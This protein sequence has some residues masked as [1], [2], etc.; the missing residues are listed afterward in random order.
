MRVVYWSWVLRFGGVTL[1]C[2]SGCSV[3]YDLSPDQCERSSECDSFGQGY[4]CEAGICKAPPGGGSSGKNGGGTA[5]EGFGGG[6]AGGT[7]EPECL[8]NAE[9]EAIHGLDD[10]HRCEDG[11]CEPVPAECATHSDCFEL[12]GDVEPV[13]CVEGRCKFLKTDECPVVV[14]TAKAELQES[15]LDY[16]AILLGAYAFV[17]PTSLVGIQTRNY[18]LVLSDFF[19]EVNGIGSPR[20]RA[21]LIVCDYQVERQANL[22][23]S[24]GHLIDELKVPAILGG[25][26]AADLQY[27]FDQKGQSADVFFLAPNYAD[28]TLVNYQD[29]GLIWHM[30]SGAEVLGKSYA[31]LLDLSVTHLQNSGAVPSEE[32]T[33]VALVTG[34]DERFLNDLGT[35]IRQSIRFNGKT[36]AANAESDPVAF[37]PVA[38]TSIYTDPAADQTPAI[39]AILGLKPHLVIAATANEMFR[40]IIPEVEARWTAEAG[41]QAPPFYLVSPFLYNTGSDLRTLLG[42]HPTVRRRMIG[43]NWPSAEDRNLYDDYQTRF[44]QA[45]PDVARQSAGYENFYDAVYYLLYGLAAARLPYSGSSI[46]DGMA[47]LVSGDP[48]RDSY[49]VGVKTSEALAALSLPSKRIH[50]IGAMGPPRWDINSGS[51]E[52]FGSVW[53]INSAGTELA[54]VLRYEESTEK[55]EGSFPSTCFPFPAPPP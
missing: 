8:E 2:A 9:C 33:R 20:R 17:P 36:A 53:C 13:A 29:D 18:E 50:L 43:I 25:L 12:H 49:Q 54:D 7:P 16:D 15:L 52:D 27:I 31:P 48:V 5:G 3:L 47:R 32:D 28:N 11:R 19:A 37:V 40:K 1:L 14:P 4:T 55:L 51:R 44:N 30:L 26:P 45:Y 39:N 41:A 23:R 38:T 42:R 21:V 24:A 34:T 46:R 22:L 10:P 35:A 6:G